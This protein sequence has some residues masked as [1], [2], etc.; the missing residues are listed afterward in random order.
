MRN[1]KL[2]LNVDITQYALTIVLMCPVM[3]HAKGKRIGKLTKM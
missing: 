1:V 3:K 2:K